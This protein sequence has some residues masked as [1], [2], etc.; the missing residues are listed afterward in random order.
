MFTHDLEE[1]LGEKPQSQSTLFLSG[2]MFPFNCSM[3]IHV[4]SFDSSLAHMHQT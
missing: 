1:T 2:L 3:S 4:G